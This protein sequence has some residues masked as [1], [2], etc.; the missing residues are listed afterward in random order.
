MLISPDANIGFNGHFDFNHF[1]TDSLALLCKSEAVHYS[2]LRAKLV[3]KKMAIFDS[4]T[5]E[6]R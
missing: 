4:S 1:S 6:N 5:N 3:K 2:V